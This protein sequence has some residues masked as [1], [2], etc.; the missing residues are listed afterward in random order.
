[1]RIRATIYFSLKRRAALY[2]S[3]LYPQPEAHIP[4]ATCTMYKM[5]SVRYSI[6]KLSPAHV[7]CNVKLVSFLQLY[8]FGRNFSLKNTFGDPMSAPKP[9]GKLLSTVCALYFRSIASCLV[10][11]I[12]LHCEKMCRGREGR[13]LIATPG[14]A[15]HP[16][17]DE[18]KRESGKQKRE[19]ESSRVVLKMQKHFPQ[20]N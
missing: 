10:R 4:C 3:R 7:Y 17:W 19:S 5:G 16:G 1:M 13:L 9:E 8:D 2:T 15:G 20:S 6:P 18:E 14:K 12:A 11:C